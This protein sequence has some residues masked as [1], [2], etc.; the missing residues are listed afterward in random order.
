MGGHGK[1]LAAAAGTDALQLIGIPTELLTGL[2]S[3]AEAERQ[4]RM[5][6][7]LGAAESITGLSREDLDS[8][9]EAN[10]DS[11]SLLVR[12]LLAAGNTGNDDVL[13]ML[14]RAL[15]T[16]VAE[17][18]AGSDREMLVMAIEG[19]TRDQILTLAVCTEDHQELV[20]IA[21]Q[22]NGQVSADVIEMALYSLVPRG[23]LANP[24]GSY[25]GGVHW[26]LSRLGAN[27]KNAALA[28][29]PRLAGSR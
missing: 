8:W 17:G 19:L 16:T 24:F 4:R 7:A 26:A 6:T 20:D 28:A 18:H 2:F 11:V 9:V 22:L 21:E 1:A 25:G 14:G 29:N 13:H 27:V 5:S 3:L 23:L 12:I 15:G 10:P